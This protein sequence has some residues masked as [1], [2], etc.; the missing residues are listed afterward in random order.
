M[1]RPAH[2]R[3]AAAI[4][5]IYNHF[6]T[7][8]TIS[9]E[10]APVSE[11]EMAQRITSVTATL[12]WLVF[13]EHNVFMGYA[14]A[15]PWRVRSAY[16]YSVESTVYVS[17]DHPKKGIGAALYTAL[18]Q[19]LRSQGLHSVIG[20]ITQPNAASVALHEKLGFVKAAHFTEVGFKFGRWVDVG[21]WELLLQNK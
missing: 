18:I 12:P 13:E 9:F 4:A 15:T 20:G 21:Y 6:V 2:P 3:D 1:I 17:V 5:A 19:A 11:Q 16:R 10:E 7:T 14:Y 8:T